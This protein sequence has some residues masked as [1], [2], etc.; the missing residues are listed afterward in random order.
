MIETYI[1]N[2]NY[3]DSSSDESMITQHCKKGLNT[4]GDSMNTETNQTLLL[5]ILFLFVSIFSGCSSDNDSSSD[6]LTGTVATGA[7]GV[8]TLYV[9]DAN[10]TEINVALLAANNGQ[11]SADVTGMTAPFI[12]G[13]DSDDNGTGTIDLYSFA[14]AVNTKANVTQL[15]TLTMFL[16]NN[17][18]DLA[19]LYADWDSTEL[20]STKIASAQAKVNAN[21]ATQINAIA[22]LE[23]ASYNFMTARFEPD[24]TSIDKLLDDITID[25]SNPNNYTV[26]ITGV[27]GFTFDATIDVSS[28][29]VDT[30]N[31]DPACSAGWC[32]YL[33]GTITQSNETV[34]IP[35]TKIKTNVSDNEVPTH[36]S[37][38]VIE[39]A[40]EEQYGHIGEISNF[41][42]EITTNTSTKVV[43]EMSAKVTSTISELGVTVNIDS[44]FN[45]IFTYTKAAP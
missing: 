37:G 41:N 17:E 7:A 6:T 22:G 1:I 3:N 43:A 44:H 36:T 8:G 24:G 9:T 12:L 2:G 34:E 39:Q 31:Y 16:A 38:L 23:S 11:Y 30:N 27:N 28:I 42:Y 21:F 10:G 19:T 29:R 33:A 15:T 45:L 13:F 14:E 26:Q 18:A 5:L 4:E 35:E 20:T 32:V 25:L 40:F